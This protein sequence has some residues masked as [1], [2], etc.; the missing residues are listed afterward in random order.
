MV[1]MNSR[2][3]MTIMIDGWDYLARYGEDACE[4]LLQARMA[5]HR[6]ILLRLFTGR[7]FSRS[8]VFGVSEHNT[9]LDA[10]AHPVNILDKIKR[11]LV[12]LVR[13]RNLSLNKSLTTKKQI[14]NDI[15]RDSDEKDEEEEGA[16]IK[17]KEEVK[18]VSKHLISL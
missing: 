1:M 7:T 17:Q 4:K 9:L 12:I 10:L 11:S 8:D 3:M 15:I 6:N 5:R 2:Q 13:D 14:L 16:W 18:D